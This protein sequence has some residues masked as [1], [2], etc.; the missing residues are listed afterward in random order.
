MIEVGRSSLDMLRQHGCAVRVETQ[1][2]PLTADCLLEVLAG[3][4]AHTYADEW[5]GLVDSRHFQGAGRTISTR[6][7]GGQKYPALELVTAPVP[8]LS[9]PRN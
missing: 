5:P 9:H 7:G 8:L 2:S 6:G 4:D 1:G 3:A